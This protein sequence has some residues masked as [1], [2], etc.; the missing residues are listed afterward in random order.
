MRRNL[1]SGGGTDRRVVDDDGL[2]FAVWTRA[3]T[4]SLKFPHLDKL[5]HSC[6]EEAYRE[7]GNSSKLLYLKP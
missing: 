5:P 7:L 6:L 1:I 2:F 3:V 4:S